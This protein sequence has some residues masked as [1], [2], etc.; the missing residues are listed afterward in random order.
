[1]ITRKYVQVMAENSIN[2]QEES[3]EGPGQC[4]PRLQCQ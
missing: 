4:M 1:M 3:R 2:V